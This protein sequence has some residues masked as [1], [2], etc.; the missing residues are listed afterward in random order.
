VKRDR[1]LAGMQK[2]LV[3]I[4]KRMGEQAAINAWLI[5]VE[6][7]RLRLRLSRVEMVADIYAP[8]GVVSSLFDSPEFNA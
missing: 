4:A 2:Q 3:E 8:P 1:Q 6:L 7:P 5:E